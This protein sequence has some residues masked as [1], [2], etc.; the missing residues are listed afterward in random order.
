MT[1]LIMHWLGG[2]SVTWSVH[3][4]PRDQCMI[5]H[6]ISA[7]SAT[8]SVHDQLRHQCMISHMISAWSNTSSVHDQSRDQF[9][10]AAWSLHD[11]QNAGWGKWKNTYILYIR[12][13]FSTFLCISGGWLLLTSSSRICCFL[14]LGVWPVRGSG[15]RLKDGGQGNQAIYFPSL[16][17][18][19]PWFS[20][21]FIMLQLLAGSLSHIATAPRD[22]K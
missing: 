2:W 20:N 21:G 12:L 8:W 10:V 17:P 14:V 16:L 22:Q 15:K 11:Q 19:E 3:D 4:Q 18:G 5:S 1:Y 9:M 13:S 7:W 6:V